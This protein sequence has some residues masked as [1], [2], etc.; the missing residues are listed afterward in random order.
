MH[1]RLRRVCADGAAAAALTVSWPDVVGL[2]A[3]MSFTDSVKEVLRDAAREGAEMLREVA[4]EGAEWAKEE[5]RAA[6]RAVWRD[7]RDHVLG[8]SGDGGGTEGHDPL[9]L[10]MAL[11]WSPWT[12]WEDVERE[13]GVTLPSGPGVYEVKRRG[14]DGPLLHIGKADILQRRCQEY[15]VRRKGPHSAGER[16]YRAEN[17]NS[18][19]VRWAE[20]QHPLAIEGKLHRRHVGAFGQL[21]LYTRQSPPMP[22]GDQD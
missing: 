13:D 2:S 4:R 6:I 7:F 12:P 11:A 16:M 5:L 1:R 21:P 3:A 22:M 15:L 19:R 10:D 9:G 14:E 17:V 20:T 18:L 8:K